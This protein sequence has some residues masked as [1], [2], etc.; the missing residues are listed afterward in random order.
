[1]ASGALAICAMLLPGISGNFL[2]LILGAYALLLAVKTLD[3]TKL[4]R[5]ELALCSAC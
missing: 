2:L 4:Q 5:S 3:V 1:M